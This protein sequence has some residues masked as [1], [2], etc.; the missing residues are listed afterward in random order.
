[1]EY[2]VVKAYECEGNLSMDREFLKGL[3]GGKFPVEEV[4]TVLTQTSYRDLMQSSFNIFD[5]DYYDKLREDCEHEI[6]DDYFLKNAKCI[7]TET[8]DVSTFET[9]EQLEEYIKDELMYGDG[10]ARFYFN[11]HSL[12]STNPINERRHA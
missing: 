11:Y 1:M 6:A 4:F 8:H 2:K 7:Y 10:K 9:L 3:A 5:V 12:T